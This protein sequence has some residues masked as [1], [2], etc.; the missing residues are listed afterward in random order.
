MRDSAIR[1]CS[2]FVGVSGLVAMAAGCAVSLDKEQTGSASA[3][4]SSSFVPT[5]GPADVLS[6]DSVWYKDVS[7]SPVATNSKA[8]TD[9]MRFGHG[10]IEV[11]FSIK[12]MQVNSSTPTNAVQFAP[13]YT[14]DSDTT[15]VPVPAGGALEAEAGYTCTQGGDCHLLV[16]AT[17]A[18]KL[19][20]L[21]SVNNTSADGSGAWTAAD[22]SVWL[23]DGHYGATGR[24]LGCTSADA[25]GLSVTA[26]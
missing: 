13:D 6:P 15:P 9:A 17:G 18:R 5:L 21:W 26:G 2:W 19:F 3:A 25:A 12:V 22:E 11:D 4:V 14:P 10:Q 20:E 23:M 7:T 8:I 24:G 1:H 16:I